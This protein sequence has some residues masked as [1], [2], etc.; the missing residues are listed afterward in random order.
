MLKTIKE[1]LSDI[2][3]PLRK[4]TAREACLECE[5]NSGKIIDVRE[6]EECKNA[7]SDIAM[8]IPRGVLEMQALEKFKDADT[9]L[10]VHCASGVRAQLA[11]E[12]LMNLGYN[13][14]SVITCDIKEIQKAG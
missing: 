6:S 2:A 1:R 11:A 9:P 8:N 7:P 4:V 5:K 14:V 10:Y 3:H 13:N 12:Q